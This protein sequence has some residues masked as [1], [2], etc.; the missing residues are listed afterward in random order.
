MCKTCVLLTIHLLGFFLGAPSLFS[1]RYSYIYFFLLFLCLLLIS[2]LLPF[3]NWKCHSVHISSPSSPPPPPPPPPPVP[4]PVVD[5]G[6]KLGSFYPSYVTYTGFW[7]LIPYYGVVN[8]NPA[9]YPPRM[10][11][12]L[13]ST[14]DVTT[15]S[16]CV[17]PADFSTVGYACS[18]YLLMD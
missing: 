10:I 7:Q 16:N 8:Y 15:S 17:C 14:S 13:H 3:P 18:C 2:H 12:E 4:C 11:A 9:S 5:V 6:G 1:Y